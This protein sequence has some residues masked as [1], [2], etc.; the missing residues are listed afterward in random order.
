MAGPFAEAAPVLARLGL[1]PLPFGGKRPSVRGFTQQSPSAYARSL[2]NLIKKFADANVGILCGPA[3]QVT[4]LDCDGKNGESMAVSFDT[5]LVVRTPSGGAHAWFRYCGERSA[6]LRSS[7]VEADVKAS[8][9]VVVVPPS[10]GIDGGSYRFLRGGWDSID[11]LP[12]LPDKIGRLLLRSTSIQSAA[13]AEQTVGKGRRN[14]TLFQL[15][16]RDARGCDNFDDLLDCA[17]THNMSFVPQL[18]DAEVTRAARSAW[19]Y[20]VKGMNMSGRGQF[21]I[22]TLSEADNL[23]DDPDAFTLLIFLRAHHSATHQFAVAIEALTR[24]LK[25]KTPQRVRNARDRL[26]ERGYLICLHR[27]GRWPGDAGTFEFSTKDPARYSTGK[28]T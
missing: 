5:P 24:R 23:T 21:A 13:P 4:V 22:V 17:R 8:G 25:W 3:S 16:L 12:P 11:A 7:G 6:N 18:S 15:L 26:V 27:G 20:E 1:R 19:G 10:V 9:G 14:N 28:K 2:P